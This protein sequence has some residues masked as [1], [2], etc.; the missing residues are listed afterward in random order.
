MCRRK[1][2]IYIR[3]PNLKKKNPTTF[4]LCN[5]LFSYPYFMYHLKC[6]LI[7]FFIYCIVYRI[8]TVNTQHMQRADVVVQ[9]GYVW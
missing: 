6:K 2:L 7:L 3:I 1:Y 5:Y 4:G 8:S 9:L